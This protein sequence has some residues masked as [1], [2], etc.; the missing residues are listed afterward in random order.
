MKKLALT[1]I[2][3]LCA[4]ASYAAQ[5]S[6]INIT[7]H[8]VDAS[9]G[10]HIPY[11][12][13]AIVGTAM[14]T[15]A[16]GTGHFNLKDVEMGEYTIEVAVMGYSPVQKQIMIDGKTKRLEMSFELAEDALAMDQVVVSSTRSATLRRNSPNLVSMLSSELFDKVSAP[17]LADGLSFQTGVRVENNCQNCGFTQVRIN[18]L[19]GSY[20]QIMVDSRPLFSAL[21]GVYGL[22]HIPANMI[23]RIEVVRGGGSAL[24]G[25]S[26]VGGTINIITKT[27]EYNSTEFAH[28]L[29]SIGMGGALDNN[30]TVN[31]SVV[32]ENQ[33]AGLSLYAQT[34]SRDGYDANGD[35]FTEIAELESH[36]FGVRSFLKT[37]DFSR[38]S[39]QFDSTNEYRRGGDNLDLPAH[40]ED[41]MIAEMVEHKVNSLGLSYDLYSHDYSRTFNIFST[42]QSTARDSYYGGEGAEAYGITSETLWITGAQLTQNLD[43]FLF[44]PS[45][46]VA[47]VE[48]NYSDLNDRY[49]QQDWEPIEQKVNVVSAYLQNEWK[50]DKWGILVGGRL[51]YNDYMD[52]AIF[53]PRA[54]LRYNPSK[55]VNLRATYST[56]FRSP[57]AFD[58]DLHIEVNQGGLVRHKLSDDLV[59]E[60][61][62]S[63]SLSADL[64]KDFG[65]VKANLLIEGFYTV[66][67][68][69]FV[70]TRTY[71]DED[72]NVIVDFDEE[73]GDDYSYAMD[74]RDN[75]AIATVKGITAEGRLAFP[76]NLQLQAGA[77]YQ[78]SLYSEPEQWSS[79]AEAT[80]QMLRT[81]DLYGY[82]TAS[83]DPIKSLSLALSGVYTGRMYVE[84]VAGYI[85]EDT[86]VH[87]PDF[88][89]AN[90]KVTYNFSLSKTIRTQLHVGVENIFNQYQSDFDEG[91]SRDAGYVYGPMKP[92]SFTC[93]LKLMF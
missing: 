29:S 60:K 76:C 58:E 87:T 30:T 24:Y 2:I 15:A 78:K 82:F 85:D 9:K 3:M 49:L 88:W 28:T 31:T 21:I 34:R 54:N 64:Y 91:V 70:C 11:A 17:T 6:G 86:I 22:E 18:G 42:A 61:S 23:D 43:H 20:S 14:G 44:M 74:V 50:S 45:Q 16:D 10:T 7:G 33:R 55:Y 48:Y 38:L 27:P 73:S 67:D 65:D 93:G 46:V 77:T 83:Y 62:Q 47:G 53:S 52:K 75:G 32:S 19:E 8:V 57:Q 1:A 25:S 41:V 4:V 39:L 90:F 12:T 79:N 26:A 63:F 68:N 40:D 80:D 92:R 84:H 72:D 35:G 69:V 5:L 59:E 56:G 89:D 81:P 37:S 36:V 51:D 66:L 13:V 71:F